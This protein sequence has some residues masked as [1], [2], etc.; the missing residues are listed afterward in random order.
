M[1][2]GRNQS[3][4][5]PADADVRLDQLADLTFGH[6]HGA[7]TTPLGT[8]AL[9]AAI[10]PSLGLNAIHDEIL[11]A[12]VNRRRQRDADTATA[13]DAYLTREARQSPF[14]SS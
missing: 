12:E 13:L 10:D 8:S 11:L 1:T 7:A 2:P 3:V 4:L 9:L 14:S 5:R 6:S